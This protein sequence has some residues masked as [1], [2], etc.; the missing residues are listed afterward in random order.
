MSDTKI[1]GH[2]GDD[3][4]RDWV[5]HAKKETVSM[6]DT[7]REPDRFRTMHAYEPGPCVHCGEGPKWEGHGDPEGAARPDVEGLRLLFEASIERAQFGDTVEVE[8]GVCLALCD[9]ILTLEREQE[10]LTGEV[11]ELATDGETTARRAEKAE[12]KLATLERRATPTETD[13]K[14]RG[15]VDRWSKSMLHELEVKRDRGTGW[16]E[17]GSRWLLDRVHEELDELYQAVTNEFGHD[18]VLA[19]AADVANM[20]FMVADAIAWEAT[21][22]AGAA[23]TAQEEDNGRVQGKRVAQEAGSGDRETDAGAIHDADDGGD[24]GREGRRLVDHGSPRGKVPVRS[25]GVQEDIRAGVDLPAALTL[26]R[27]LADALESATVSPAEDGLLSDA[28]AF[29]AG[30]ATS[31]PGETA[32]PRATQAGRDYAAAYAEDRDRPVTRGGWLADMRLAFDTAYAKARHKPAPTAEPAEASGGCETCEHYWARK[33]RC[34]RMDNDETGERRY[35]TEPSVRPPWCPG[36]E[37]L[38][39]AEPES[40]DD[41]GG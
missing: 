11:R 15:A 27:R 36:Y 37:A 12:A 26:V 8:R 33:A 16:R 9:Y 5:G 3:V 34:V 2:E 23:E 21:Q 1:G 41:H 14:L 25:R 18:E 19:E 35:W 7:P 24:A 20:A 6:T 32:E 22:P 30:R 28:G 29:L 31:D 13:C 4:A 39:T 38:Q 40:E 17:M 10:R